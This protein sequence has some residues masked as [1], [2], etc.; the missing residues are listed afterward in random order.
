M[1]PFS[2]PRVSMGLVRAA[3]VAALGLSLALPSGR[4]F[5][6]QAGA[7]KGSFDSTLSFGGLYRLK[8]PN[9]MYY[10][11]SNTFNGIPGL[12]TSVNTDDGNLNYGQG[13]VS[14]I[15]KGSHEL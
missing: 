1:N 13:W 4:A 9:P 14:E 3:L 8:D 11:T 15:F 5:P 6:F 2:L 7:V 10:G 12:Q